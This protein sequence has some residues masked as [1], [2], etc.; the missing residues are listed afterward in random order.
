METI[1]FNQ[2]IV[3]LIP[4]HSLITIDPFMPG[5]KAQM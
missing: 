2:L 1:F 5:W 4:T 3:S